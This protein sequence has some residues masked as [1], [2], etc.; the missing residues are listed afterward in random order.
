M[1]YLWDT[2]IKWSYK[3]NNNKTI[4]IINIVILLK[5]EHTLYDNSND[6]TH[7]LMTTPK[8]ELFQWGNKL[9]VER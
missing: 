9:H 5:I 3:L 7:W 6:I 2:W 4:N 1:F 8:N